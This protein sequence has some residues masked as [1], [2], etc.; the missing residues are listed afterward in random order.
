LLAVVKLAD[1]VDWV[2]PM[3]AA[4]ETMHEIATNEIELTTLD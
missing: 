1:R 4:H 2:A 3:F